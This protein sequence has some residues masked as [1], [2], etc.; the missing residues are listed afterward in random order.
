MKQ[1]TPNSQR[2]VVSPGK[3]RFF[4]FGLFFIFLYVLVACTNPSVGTPWGPEKNP[5]RRFT[6]LPL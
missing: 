3:F 2:I 5:A 6:P 1:F 4:I